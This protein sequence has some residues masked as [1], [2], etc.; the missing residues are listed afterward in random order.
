MKDCFV[1]V[2]SSTSGSKKKK[3][4]SFLWSNPK[5][6]INIKEDSGYAQV[7]YESKK[8][9]GCYC[10]VYQMKKGESKFYRDGYSDMT[11]TF[12][13]ALADLEGVS[14]FSILFVTEFGG[15]VRRMKPPSQQAYLS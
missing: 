3:V 12:K 14:E 4:R 8:Q 5:I 13:Y 7:F 1:E 10:K 9:A 15:V 6:K 2:Y 11:G